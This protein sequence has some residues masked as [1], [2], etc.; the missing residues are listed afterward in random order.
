MDTIEKLNNNDLSNI[1]DVV[2]SNISNENLIQA[3]LLDYN[4]D[5][6][7]I[8]LQYATFTKDYKTFVKSLNVV[9]QN[10]KKH[11]HVTT[12]KFPLSNKN[13]YEILNENDLY[14]ILKLQDKSNIEHI[15][16]INK[17]TQNVLASINASDIEKSLTP[18]NAYIMNNNCILLKRD[19][20]YIWD[21]K[22]NK[23]SHIGSLK[24]NQAI[25]IYD[26]I[27]LSVSYRRGLDITFIEVNSDNTFNILHHHIAYCMRQLIMKQHIL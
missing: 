1:I 26:N 13:K 12:V 21:Y 16:V 25:Y 20:L 2:Y 14:I 23:V 10:L 19:F 18:C 22:Q 9:Q 11:Q 4:D 5:F 7:N 24:K 27:L 15:I 8:L 17:F 6:K 3:K